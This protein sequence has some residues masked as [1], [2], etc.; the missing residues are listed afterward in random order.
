MCPITGAFCQTVQ[1]EPRMAWEDFVT[2]M[3]EGN[4]EEEGMDEVLMERLE[5]LY[6]N[7][8]DINEVGKEDLDVLPFLS[9]EQVDGI[10]R[11]REKNGR[12]ES[13]GELMMVDGLGKKEREML[14]MFVKVDEGAQLK[15]DRQDRTLKEMLKYGKNEAVWRS[16]VPFYKKAGYILTDEEGVRKK[17]NKVYR[18]DRFHHSFRYA[19]SG[20]KHVLA[21]VQMEKDAGESGIDYVTGY[22]M[23]KDIGC[24]KSAVLGN[25]RVSFG[26]GL[27]INSGMKFGKMMMLSTMDRMDAGF[28]KHSSMSESGYFTGGATT[29]QFGNWQFSA[30]GSHRKGDGTYATDSMGMS[31]LK[32]DGLHR[33]QL[34]WSKKGNLGIRNFGGNVHWEHKQLRLSATAVWTHLDVPLMPKYN[35]K[36]SAYRLY[37]ASDQN[38][39]VGSVAYA[40]RYKSLT[41]SGETA[42]SNTEKQNGM[43]SLNFLRWQMNSSNL[44]MLIGRFYGAKFVSLNGKSFGEN[45][46]VQN[47]DGMFVGWR[48]RS[49]RNLELEAYIDAMYFP[50]LKQ[51]VSSSSYGMEGMMQALYSPNRRWNL[52][53]RYRLKSKQLDF[54]MDTKSK[55]QTMLCYDTHHTFNLQLN[56][57]LSSFLSLRTSA[58]GTLIRFGT[59]PDET[60]YAVGENIRWQHP[61][62]KCRVDLGITYFNT[63]TYNAR[64]YNYEPS[65]LY[66]FGS[67]SYYDQGIRTTLLAS[68]PIFKNKLF[69]Y[70]KFGMTKYFNR[71]TISSDLELIDANHREDLQLQARWL[72]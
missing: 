44:L 7:P 20:M 66:T 53:A 27:A 2:V 15:R 54:K 22:V 5:E 70:A 65:L 24:V 68:L 59:N 58:T 26:K 33:T 56:C 17:M 18:G 41:I 48:S 69:L 4:D 3:T 50:W 43:A 21:G 49:F 72:F 71:D 40:Y 57:T 60:G 10:L 13:L 36:A 16:D 64:V 28:M 1:E 30:F 32:T 51:G 61:K 6:G 11:Y 62:T 67:T 8:M 14:R 52:L 23:L 46:L 34:E 38:F 55:T 31:S 9:E 47:E 42:L 29:L 39:M 35:T 63:D 45:S 12:M 37:N 19:F 25:Y